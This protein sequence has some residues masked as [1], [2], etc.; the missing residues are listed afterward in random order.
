MTDAG[1]AC[2]LFK[3][4]GIMRDADTGEMIPL[5]RRG[6]LFVLGLAFRRA[7]LA[8]DT[9]GDLIRPCGLN[10]VGAGGKVNGGRS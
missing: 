10:E 4:G 1:Y 2:R 7:K 8:Q 9:P 6:N 3:E 5:I